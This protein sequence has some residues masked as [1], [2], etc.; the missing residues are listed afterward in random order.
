MIAGG[1]LVARSYVRRKRTLSHIWPVPTGVMTP[2]GAQTLVKNQQQ[3]PGKRIVLAGSGPFLLPGEKTLLGACAH[4]DAILEVRRARAWL[5][6]APRL[7]G[8]RA[9]L[10]DG[11]AC[12]DRSHVRGS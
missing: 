5:G 2:G 12:W 10:A 7:G 3:L 9:S 4:I 8:H 1:A 11:P 6:P